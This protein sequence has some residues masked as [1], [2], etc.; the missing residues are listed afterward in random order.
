MPI[1]ERVI[2]D[3]AVEI[4]DPKARQTFIEKACEGN[5]ELFARVA[6]LLKSHNEA[7]SFLEIPAVDFDGKLPETRADQKLVNPQV[8]DAQSSTEI[9][10][11][12]TPGTGD[13]GEMIPVM[14]TKPSVVS[15]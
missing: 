13:S 6:A 3:A 11:A 4:S 5:A 9:V 7:G 15:I 12:F 14:M 8:S 2:F 1:N 10:R